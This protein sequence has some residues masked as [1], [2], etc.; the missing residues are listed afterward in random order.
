VYCDA[1]GIQNGEELASV[2]V[3]Y[4]KTLIETFGLTKEE[5][6]K[7][8]QRKILTLLGDEGLVPIDG[9]RPLRAASA[10]TFYQSSMIH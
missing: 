2:V 9:S 3:S 10:Q 7:N 1:R 6:I 5:G 8:R 4:P